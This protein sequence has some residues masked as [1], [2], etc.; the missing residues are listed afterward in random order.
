MSERMD[1][2]ELKQ[3]IDRADGGYVTLV[4]IVPVPTIG[5]VPPEDRDVEL[6]VTNVEFGEVI[7]EDQ[8]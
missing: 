8:V 7:D 6:E 4:D 2:E 3:R 5:D 1:K